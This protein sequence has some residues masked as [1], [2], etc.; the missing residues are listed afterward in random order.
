MQPD[1]RP[2]TPDCLDAML[3]LEQ[4]AHSTPWSRQL[5]ASC[6]SERY[7]SGSLWQ[8]QTLLGFYIAD[9]VLDESTLMNVCVTPPCQGRG[10]GRRLMTLYIE[11]AMARQVSQLWLEVRESNQAARRL[12][13]SVGFVEQGRRKAYYSSAQGREDAVIMQ[14]AL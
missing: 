10:L 11:S 8:G 2:L 4:A 6:F 12:Y 13:L 9:Q 5:L 1:Y 7:F 3:A 14:K